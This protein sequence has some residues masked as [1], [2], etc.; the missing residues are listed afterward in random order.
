MTHLTL[1]L[2]APKQQLV[3]RVD[4]HPSTQAP[5]DSRD[6]RLLRQLSL[7]YSQAKDEPS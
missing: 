7:R 1:S 6:T 4:D 2:D 5:F 3:F